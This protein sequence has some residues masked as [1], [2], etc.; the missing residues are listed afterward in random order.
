MVY[1]IV[2]SDDIGFKRV[3]KITLPVTVQEEDQF[4]RKVSGSLFIWFARFD[5][6][7]ACIIM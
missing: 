2:R 4:P 3:S 1:C 6:G 7:M 5:I